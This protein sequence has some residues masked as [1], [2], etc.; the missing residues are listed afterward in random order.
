[1]NPTN[2]RMKKP[3]S[4]TM[5]VSIFISMWVMNTSTTL[6]L[7]PICLAICVNIKEAKYGNQEAD[8]DDLYVSYD[9]EGNITE[10]P[11]IVHSK[12][13]EKIF[14]DLQQDEV[15]LIQPEFQI[16][17]KQLIQHFQ[18]ETAIVKPLR[19]HNTTG[20]TSRFGVKF[21]HGDHLYLEEEVH[22]HLPN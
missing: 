16:L 17:Y 20:A 2:I 12:V 1:M 6:M 19:E 18:L 7:L 21:Y 3:I 10:E 4:R 8:F 13:H 11:K 15:E 22:Q 9:E 14:L 5:R